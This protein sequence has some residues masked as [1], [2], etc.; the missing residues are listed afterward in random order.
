MDSVV[1][2]TRTYG[3]RIGWAKLAVAAP[4]PAYIISEIVQKWSSCNCNTVLVMLMNIQNA[5]YGSDHR[6]LG[7]TDLISH[8]NKADTEEEGEQDM[9]RSFPASFPLQLPA[10]RGLA[11]SDL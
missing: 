1:V 4:L 6:I 2:S 11:R 9:S 10:L 7:L 5:I 8:S 3:R